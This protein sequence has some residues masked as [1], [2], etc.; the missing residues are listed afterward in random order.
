MAIL[1]AATHPER[2][3]SLVLGNTTA[4]YLAAPDYPAGVSAEAAERG[5]RL[6]GKVWGTI[7]Y[8][9]GLFPSLAADET[10]LWNIARCQRAS[11]TPRSAEAQLRYFVSV[12][13]RDA[14]SLIQAPTLVLHSEGNPVFPVAQGEYLASHIAGARLV[15]WPSN[16]NSSTLSTDRYMD[17][18]GEFL[19]GQRPGP[20]PDR[21][22]ATIL[23]TDIVGSTAQVS[24][25]G[26]AMWRHVL[27]VHDRIVRQQLVRFGGREINTTGDGFV[28]AFDGPARAIR[29]GLAMIHDLEERGIRIR[30]GCHT[31]ECERRGDDLAGLAVH[32]A[33]RIA[34]AARAT[35]LLVSSTV[36]DLVLGSG[37]EFGTAGQHDLKGVP[38]TWQLLAVRP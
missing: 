4:R 20:E 9:R 19:T 2:V 7:E 17:V 25:I 30:A 37:I 5:V 10:S 6:V 36:G 29:C 27:D 3:T 32:I 33:A 23:F 14:L 26:D 16:D 22:L 28:A 8:V 13:V 15:T 18:V 38:G 31:G 21:V 12:D 34:G 35:E 24:R 11:A 1:F